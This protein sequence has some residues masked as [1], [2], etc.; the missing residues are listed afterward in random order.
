[1][2]TYQIR[3]SS[4]N[5]TIYLS[6]AT[7]DDIESARSILKCDWLNIWNHLYPDYEAIVK[8][9]CD[10]GIQGLIHFALYPYPQKDGRPEYLEVI[11]IEAIQ[12]PIRLKPV[13]LF[14]LWYATK[15]SLD[16]GCSGND[17]GSIVEL[18]A[19]ET[20]ID[21]YR[22]KVKMEGKGWVTISPTEEG[23]AFRFSKEQAIEFCARIEQ[24]YGIPYPV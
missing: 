17:E 22:N 15:I 18:D 3:L 1:M 19:P 14:L 11:H 20:A 16:F 13:G 4:S 7:R 23:Y 9:E 5:Q 10:S 8:L 2:D 21:Y 12:S 24:Q 6:E